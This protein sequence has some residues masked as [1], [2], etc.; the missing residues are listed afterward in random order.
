MLEGYIDVN[1]VNL[2]RTL[3]GTSP[4]IGAPQFG[5]R[6]RLYLLDLYRNPEAMARIIAKSYQLGVRGIQLLPYPPVVEALEIARD[7]GFPMDILATIRPD[8]E[9]DA[10][11]IEILSQ[12]NAKAILL[13][14]SLTDQCNW[15]L[16]SEKLD[17]IK[18]TGAISGLVTHMPFKTTSKLL[19]S[20]II[21]DFQIY[22]VPVNRLGYL[23]DC[24][25]HGTEDRAKFRELLINLDK[26]II[27]KKVLAA[28]IMTPDDAFDYLKT[29]DFVD[30]VALGIASEKEAEETFQKL[31]ER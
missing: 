28:G 4:F 18:N 26:T 8:P 27:A 11:D 10:D 23:M 13:H 16:L 17:E 25:T 22:M 6:A 24:D 20:H 30:M 31:A 12:L 7:N 9:D 2:P 19:D 15:D 3:L 29:L 5:H 1:G 14:A 21:D